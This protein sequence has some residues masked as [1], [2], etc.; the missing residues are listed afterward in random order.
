[1]DE[2]GGQINALALSSRDDGTY[3]A[4][5]GTK[6]PAFGYKTYRIE[7]SD[8]I[9][10]NRQEEQFN[11]IL[12][13]QYYKIVFDTIKGGIKSFFDKECGKELTDGN[14]PWLMGQFIYESLG[15][16]RNQIELKRLDEVTRT[17]LKNITFS[18]IK[19]SGIWKSVSING[20]SPVCADP[21]G[22]NIEF[23]LYEVEKRLEIA[24]SMK[25]LPV[26]D[27]EAAY[28]AFPFNIGDSK[29]HF[30]VP[31]GDVVAGRDQIEGSS[32]DWCGIQN[33]ASVTAKDFQV[34]ISSPEIPLMQFGDLNLGKFM[35]R[36]EIQKP[37]M[38]S[39][40]LNNYWTT[41]FL[42]SQ[43]GELKW[44]YVITSSSDI[45]NQFRNDFGWG[46]RIPFPA[47]VLPASEKPYGIKEQSFLPNGLSDLL[48]ITAEPAENASNVNFFLREINGN[49]LKVNVAGNGSI[50]FKPYET[51]MVELKP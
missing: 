23:R 8:K 32:A 35:R 6:I 41:N 12:E 24:C 40:V 50:L 33:Y 22:V 9:Q 19:R 1:M 20:K 16:N 47:R 25:K 3:W 49:S 10:S 48:L 44:T 14:A 21:D 15:K 42:A 11:G 5:Y 38:Y 29:I 36:T 26:T 27:P 39:W 34:V 31:G 37:Y 51:K 4:F 28:I 2:K 18:K 45:S 43:Q 30:D 13:N 7:V 46:T 17:A